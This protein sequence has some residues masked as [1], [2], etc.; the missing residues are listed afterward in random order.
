[1]AEYTW[2]EYGRLADLAAV[3]TAWTTRGVH[4]RGCG[5]LF[6]LPLIP[7]VSGQAYNNASLINY[8]GTVKW[9]VITRTNEDHSSFRTYPVR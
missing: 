2:T 4:D 3:R 5:F 6:F 1:M 7:L 8:L 9:V